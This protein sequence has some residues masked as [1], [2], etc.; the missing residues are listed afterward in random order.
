MENKIPSLSLRAGALS[1]IPNE[2]VALY[3]NAARRLKF[4]RHSRSSS[5]RLCRAKSLRTALPRRS[6]HKEAVLAN[7]SAANTPRQEGRLLSL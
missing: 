6:R 1:G 2:A 5:A 4:C 7:V 3:A